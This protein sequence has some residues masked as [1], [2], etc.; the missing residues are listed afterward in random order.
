MS[1][2][3]QDIND[4]N[5]NYQVMGVIMGIFSKAKSE[6]NIINEEPNKS[7]ERLLNQDVPKPMTDT[8][9]IRAQLTLQHPEDE[10]YFNEVLDR[11]KC[12]AELGDVKAQFVLG[13]YYLSEDNMDIAEKW[14]RL[15]SD[16]GYGKAQY[17]LA[18]ILLKQY[19]LDN[20]PRKIHDALV[21]MKKA[22]Y[23]NQFEA[24]D[25]MRN[26]EQNEIEEIIQKAKQVL[27]PE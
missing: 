15:A 4:G 12:S 20:E 19:K 10:K 17:H 13:E 21:L 25:F 7:L 26:Y 22:A 16:K 18:M 24:A 2:D 6:K 8:D 23:K 9:E 3:N 14:L 27:I 5:T 11:V 1:F